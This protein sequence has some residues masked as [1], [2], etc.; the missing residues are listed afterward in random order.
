MVRTQST[1]PIYAMLSACMMSAVLIGTPV[2]HTQPILRVEQIVDGMQRHEINQSGELKHYEAVRH[3]Q[4][5]Y[6]GFGK[7]IAATMDVE[8]NFDKLSGKSFRIV[9]QGGSKLLCDKVLK[10]AVDSEGEASKDKSSTALNATNY[11]FRLAGA[12]QIDGRPTYILH[13]DPVKESKFLYR[14]KVWVDAADYAVVKIEVEPAK[15]PSFW[16]SST[17]IENTSSKTNGV[18]LPR[19]NRSESRI[20]IGGTA[21]LTIDYGTY[22][23]ALVG[24]PQVAVSR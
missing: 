2:A 8:I 9:S 19:E 7:L 5:Q 4:V 15:N 23:V 10:R 3:Y 12:E 16:I 1:V 14:G 20:R 17:K 6:K 21:V 13:V 18:W 11:R 24:Q 22:H